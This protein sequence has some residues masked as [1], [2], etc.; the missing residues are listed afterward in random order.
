VP[1]EFWGIVVTSL[2]TV[3]TVLWQPARV[4][5]IPLAT[6]VVMI[7]IFWAARRAAERED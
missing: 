3:G 1:A 6:V 4:L 5:A 7:A 2:L